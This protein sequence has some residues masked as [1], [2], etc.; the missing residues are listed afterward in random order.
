MHM[1]ALPCANK[2]LVKTKLPELLF[3]GKFGSLI[4]ILSL[5]SSVYTPAGSSS[6]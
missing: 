1:S 2:C 6:K 4:S 3:G 5:F